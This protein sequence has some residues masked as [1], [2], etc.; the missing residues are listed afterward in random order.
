MNCELRAQCYVGLRCVQLYVSLKLR[1]FSSCPPGTDRPPF[2]ECVICCFACLIAVDVY[3]LEIQMCYCKANHTAQSQRWVLLIKV[4][5]SL[6][7]TKYHAMKTYWGSGGIAPRALDL[8]TRWRWVVSF[9]PRP[10]Y[11][12]SKSSRFLLNR[13]LGG[14]Q[15]RS[16]R[17]GKEKISH[18]CRC[19]ELD[20]GRLA[21]S[22]VSILTELPR[23]VFRVI[24]TVSKSVSNKICRPSGDLH[25]IPCNNFLYIYLFS[26]K[27][28]RLYL[29]FM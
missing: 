16:G 14:P 23:L 10:L 26:G 12:R 4:N 28:V 1:L 5:F 17:V 20:P 15:S 6:F 21:C 9:M 19:R 7:L 22:L 13:R 3:L 2:H 25:F 8:S 27:L 18:H 24:W 11:P 29:S